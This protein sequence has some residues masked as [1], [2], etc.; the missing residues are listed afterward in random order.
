MKTLFITALSILAFSQVSS[1]TAL[2]AQLQ[3]AATETQL[4]RQTDGHR[5]AKV[6]GN[7]A[8]VETGRSESADVINVYLSAQPGD[9]EYLSVL[10]EAEMVTLTL[11]LNAMSPRGEASQ[12]QAQVQIQGDDDQFRKASGACLLDLDLSLKCTLT[13]TFNA[14]GL[15]EDTSL[16][17]TLN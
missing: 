1:A 3:G 11:D 6:V 13:P 16:D 12:I 17:L 4:V 8:L 5:S 2:K 14:F 10:H 9:A 7:A 15:L